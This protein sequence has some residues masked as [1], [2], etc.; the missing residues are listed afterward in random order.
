MG[1]YKYSVTNCGR[2]GHDLACHGSSGN[3]CRDCLDETRDARMRTS[4]LVAVVFVCDNFE[5][6]LDMH[7]RWAREFDALVNGV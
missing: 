5:S 7:A 6:E 4:A 1:R 2:C 3:G